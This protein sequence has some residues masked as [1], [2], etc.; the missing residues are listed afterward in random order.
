MKHVNPGDLVVSIHTDLEGTGLVLS[1]D[2]DK[3]EMVPRG[4]IVMWNT[5][6]IY[7]EWEDE[8]RLVNGSS[9]N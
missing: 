1:I 7:R 3:D 9:T 6:I 5:G 8:V 2:E 4:V